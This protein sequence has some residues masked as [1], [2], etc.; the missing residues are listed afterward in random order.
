VIRR[1]RAQAAAVSAGTRIALLS[2]AAWATACSYQEDWYPPSDGA[3]DSGATS[4]N[5]A[6]DD[7]GDSGDAAPS[8]SRG[9]G[10]SSGSSS[11]GGGGS[12]S[13]SSSSSSSGSS[14]DSGP[15]SSGDGGRVVPPAVPGP[16]VTFADFATPTLASPGAICAGP[17]GRIW[18]LFQQG[19]GAL[20]AV[21]LDGQNFG[22]INISVN[23]VGPV[24]IN[25]GPDGNVWYTKQQGIGK[26]MPSALPSNG[27][28][29][30]MSG[31]YQEFGAPMN[32]ETAGIV[33]GP[34]GN[35]WFA[36]PTPGMIANITTSGQSTAYPLPGTNRSPTDITVGPDGNLWYTDTAANVIGR[37]TTSGTITEYPIPTPAS[38]P[39]AIC[40]GPKGDGNLWFV[41]HDAHNIGRITPSGEIT[42]FAI[43]SGGD[44]YAIAA[45]PDGNLWFTE[46][47]AFNAI[48]RCT[49]SGGISEYSIP[50]PNAEVQGITAGPDGNMWFA[51]EFAGKIGRFSDLNGGGTLA[52]G[53]LAMAP[54]G[55][56]IPMC[57]KDTDCINSGM[58][59][60]GDVCSH[61]A[62]TPACVLADTGDPGWC[63]TSSDCWC[64]PQGATCD[65]SSHHCSTTGV[66]VAGPDQ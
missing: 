20:G 46:P 8:S 60:G 40:G 10:S 65:T 37:I 13:S 54:L 16:K 44:P 58:G 1:A 14:G 56:T 2:A 3:G 17:D 51:E 52:S 23:G 57:T 62:T 26:V 31:G 25:P 64:A 33:Q 30:I 24:G 49:P 61:A 66:D 34:D 55:G 29:V 32:G 35:M 21:T 47:G 18:F 38:D 19:G 7:G 4:A 12:G 6:G 28:V 53:S 59:C 50:T 63:T 22:Q 9:S 39:R 11:S 48:G 42:E 5:G 45:G 43:P 36:M 27:N 15:V 41:E